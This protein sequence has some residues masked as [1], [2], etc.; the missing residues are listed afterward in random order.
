MSTL[1]RHRG[2]VM[3]LNTNE[4][5]V[6]ADELGTTTVVRANDNE[7]AEL[8]VVGSA[9]FET[10]LLTDHEP[11]TPGGGTPPSTAGET[12]AA[13]EGRFMGSHLILIDRL[14]NLESGTPGG[15][16]S[17][18]TAGGTPAAT[19]AGMAASEGQLELGLRAPAGGRPKRVVRARRYAVAR[20]WF[21]RMRETVRSTR[22]WN[23]SEVRGSGTEQALLTLTQPATRFEGRR[24][25]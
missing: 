19:A 18:S 10:E 15:E 24:A 25:A 20:W 8:G 14:T 22:E 6:L 4:M 3:K 21:A 5:E 16:T 17:P 2:G 23:G 12:P 7:T 13:T 1:S 9:L 11:G